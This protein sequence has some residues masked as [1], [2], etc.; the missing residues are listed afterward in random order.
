MIGD[1]VK[2]FPSV[3]VPIVSPPVASAAVCDIW[4]DGGDTVHVTGTVTI[5]SFGVAPRAGLLKKVIFDGALTLTH[6][7]NLY[8]PGAANITTAVDDF[9][10]VYADTTTQFDCL[11]FPRSGN[12][13]PA[14]TTRGDL[15]T[16]NATVP[17]RLA[18]GA[19][20][21][22]LTSDGTDPAWSATPTVTSLAA[23]GSG[24]FGSTIDT[25]TRLAIYRAATA[26]YATTDMRAGG[27]LTEL[28]A[29]DNDLGDAGVLSIQSFNAVI[30]IAA[31]YSA[32]ST[33]AMALGTQSGGNVLERVRINSDGVVMFGKTAPAV[34]TVGFECTQGGVGAFTVGA[35][36]PLTVNRRTDDG[37]LIELAQADVLEGAISVSGATV[38]YGTFCGGHTSQLQS[39]GLPNILRGTVVSSVDEMCEWFAD[40][41]TDINGVKHHDLYTGP[42]AVGAT[43]TAAETITHPIQQRK[44]R[45][46][47][48]VLA[49]EMRGGVPTMIEQ[50]KEYDKGVTTRKQVMLSDGSPHLVGGKA[51]FIDVPVLEDAPRVETAIITHR[52]VREANDQ[53]P[54]F[55][56]SDLPADPA[57]YGV[58]AVWDGDG[59][60]LIH[61]L[62]ATVIRVTGLARAGDLLESAGDGTARIQ[63]SPVVLRSTIG[64]VTSTTRYATHADGSYVVPCVLYCG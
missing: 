9:C 40:E 30:A 53:L 25:N 6:S 37:N 57:V 39:G 10:F 45:A 51:I 15:L 56:V 34:S 38:T 27:W 8:L 13:M 62:G 54:K 46:R 44:E 28:R 18:V 60:A 24:A 59:D 35:A 52:I 20:N 23:T 11:Y 55:K 17:I 31:L 19:A 42:L 12:F 5:T 26:N 33:S 1:D 43:Y 2:G 63:A 32:T 16:R 49:M 14:L 48:T 21:S 36:V 22:V 3:P 4:A 58:F 41:W 61:A 50:V 47:E 29:T 64:K 7:A